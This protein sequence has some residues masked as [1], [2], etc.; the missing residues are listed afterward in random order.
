MECR[1]GVQFRF[2][3]IPLK[4]YEL[5]NNFQ[6]RKIRLN[7]NILLKVFLYDKGKL[8]IFSNFFANKVKC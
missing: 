5:L 1:S 6:Q 7:Q 4:V 8:K 3:A 2:L